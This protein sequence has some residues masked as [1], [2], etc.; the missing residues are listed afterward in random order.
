[1]DGI[2]FRNSEENYGYSIVVATSGLYPLPTSAPQM[3]L[4]GGYQLSMYRERL[5]LFCTSEV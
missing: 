1:M 3:N 2:I 4:G 5:H